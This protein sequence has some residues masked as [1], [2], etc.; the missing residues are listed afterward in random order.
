MFTCARILNNNNN[1]LT[2]SEGSTGKYPTVSLYWPSDSK[3]QYSK[4]EVGYFK[5]TPIVKGLLATIFL[6][7]TFALEMWTYFL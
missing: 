2:E 4:T 3:G 1:L 6:K 5:R 7:K